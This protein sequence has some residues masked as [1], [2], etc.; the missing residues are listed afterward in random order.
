MIYLIQYP[1]YD[2]QF[3]LIYS[4]FPALLSVI[5]FVKKIVIFWLYIFPRFKSS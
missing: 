2:L 3:L 5:L 4:S 1:S